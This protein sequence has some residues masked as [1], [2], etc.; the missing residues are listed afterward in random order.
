MIA[1][2]QCMENSCPHVVFSDASSYPSA[3]VLIAAEL[4]LEVIIDEILVCIVIK[5]HYPRKV[6][7][8]PARFLL[9]EVINRARQPG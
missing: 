3:K 9:L 1:M 8:L 6:P 7:Q 5:L 2:V 4:L